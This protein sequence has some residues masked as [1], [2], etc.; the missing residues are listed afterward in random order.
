M[1]L[2]AKR[3][4]T[5]IHADSR[6]KSKLESIQKKWMQSRAVKLFAQVRWDNHAKLS[7][8]HPE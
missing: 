8:R 1:W 7:V 2:V 3:G 5:N 4:L 6:F